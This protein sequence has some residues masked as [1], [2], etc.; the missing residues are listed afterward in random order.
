M[1]WNRPC[2]P[3]SDRSGTP[4]N[5]LG[6][7][8]LPAGVAAGHPATAAAGLAVLEAGGSAADSA[9]AMILAGCVS[10]TIFCGLNGG[11]FAT[12]YEAATSTVTCL[13]FFVA[14]PGLDGTVAAPAQNISVSFGSVA[15]PYA[16]G[17][18]SVA[19]AGTPG[20]L[21]NSTTASAVCPGARWSPQPWRWRR[22]GSSSPVL[23]RIC[24]PRSLRR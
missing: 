12:V 3:R 14:V 8:R 22:T 7:S 5:L 2:S 6:V 18:P 15:V 23:M 11:G 4:G 9:A 10:E 21:L 13:D 20:A 24:C 17:G 16:I 19:V 1:S